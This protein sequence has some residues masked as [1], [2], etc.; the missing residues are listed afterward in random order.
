MCL[1]VYLATDKEIPEIKWNSTSPD[2]HVKRENNRRKILN[3][4]V[5]KSL[6]YIGSNEGCG[7][8]FLLEGIVEASE[9]WEAKKENY[10]AF[11]R[12]LYLN[13]KDETVKI[14]VCW[15]GDQEKDP[16]K[17]VRINIDQIESGEFE[18]EELTQYLI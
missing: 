4:M 16:K 13:L 3:R 6:Y 5:S 15:E 11:A 9:Q 7:C 18:F 8:G 1:A 10:R 14:F 2:F 17:E 12:Y